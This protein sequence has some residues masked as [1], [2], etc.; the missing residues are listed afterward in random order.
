[1]TLRSCVSVPTALA[2]ATERTMSN[3]RHTY[4]F[5]ETESV[6][7]MEMLVV[8]IYR[9]AG[10]ACSL[11]INV[12]CLDG[13]ERHDATQPTGIVEVADKITQ[14]THTHTTA[15]EQQSHARSERGAVELDE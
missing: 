3:C 7:F 12:L 4:T 2:L 15:T 14:P 10:P 9:I 5:T 13:V 11:A 6:S 8:D 1:M